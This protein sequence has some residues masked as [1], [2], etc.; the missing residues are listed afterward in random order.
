MWNCSTYSL[1]CECSSCVRVS[2]EGNPT[3]DE[4]SHQRMRTKNWFNL[5]KD[6]FLMIS[7]V[8][9]FFF[10]SLFNISR[11]QQW[12]FENV[13]V[14][15]SIG[16]YRG[17][18]KVNWIQTCGRVSENENWHVH[19]RIIYELMTTMSH[20]LNTHQMYNRIFLLSFSLFILLS[21]WNVKYFLSYI[22]NC[23][24][25]KGITLWHCMFAI[26]FYDIVVVVVFCLLL[27]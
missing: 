23:I 2:R 7:F 6:L 8:V 12:C 26:A 4:E 3:E 15:T 10:L 18:S 16:C 21:Y 11:T 13:F 9:F 1:T 27:T 20:T 5:S 14:Y 19:C 24:H 17:H 22:F 25:I